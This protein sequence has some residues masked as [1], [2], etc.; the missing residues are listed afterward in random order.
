[1]DEGPAG[2]PRCRRDCGAR[3]VVPSREKI[4]G[5]F[6]GTLIPETDLQMMTEK[7]LRRTRT[8]LH[9]F[10]LPSPTPRDIL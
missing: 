3:S 6:K 9:M 8:V 10:A 4:A 1:M 5:R 7:Q 2:S